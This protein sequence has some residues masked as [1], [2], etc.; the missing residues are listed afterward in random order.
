MIPSEKPP[1][2]DGPI[3]RHEAEFAVAVTLFARDMKTTPPSIDL[4]GF[5]G[6]G[7]IIDWPSGVSYTTQSAGYGCE[8]AQIEGVMVP[9][10]DGVGRPVLHALRQHFRGDWHA[11]DD[12]A[13]EIIDRILKRHDLAFIRADRE[14]LI[15]SREAWIFVT[16]DEDLA[17]KLSPRI[18]GFG[19]R[20]GVLTWP[21]SD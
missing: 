6:L 12:K 10:F 20:S 7:L 3:C 17:P 8:H 19:R 13:A 16:V 18:E 15:D 1:V 5:D 21:N 11:I 4:I 14:R 9:L 2:S